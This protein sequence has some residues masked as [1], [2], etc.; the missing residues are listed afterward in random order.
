MLSDHQALQPMLKNSAHKQYSARLTRWLD[1]LSHFDVNVQYT[2]GKNIPLTDYLSRHP[3]VNTNENAAENKYSGR[4]ETESEEEFVINQIHGLF[5]FIQTNGS[6]KRF[7]ER[8]K[9][10]QKIDQSQRGTCKREQNRQTHLLEASIPLNSVNQISSTKR[11][12][13]SATISNMDKVNG[14]EVSFIYKKEDTH[15]IHTDSGQKERDFLNP[16]R[17]EL[18]AKG[19]TT[20]E[21]R[22]IDLH[23]KFENELWS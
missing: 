6:I 11:S 21:Y 7:A 8:T 17:Q 16:K 12:S 2:A 23:N 3:I 19:Q 20:K 10:E 22:S 14:I 18:S 4:N 1:R 5:D 9:P 13:K 15:E